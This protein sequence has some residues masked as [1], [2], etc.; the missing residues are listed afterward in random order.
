MSKQLKVL[1]SLLALVFCIAYAPS[2]ASAQ[3][4]KSE[5]CYRFECEKVPTACPEKELED[6]GVEGPGVYTSKMQKECIKEMAKD[7]TIRVACKTEYSDQ[8]HALDAAQVTKNNKH[9]VMAYAALWGIVTL[10][11]IGMWLRQRKL[12]VKISN[13]ESDLKK[14]AAE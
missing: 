4:G 3:A 13:L 6:D 5:S 12:I 10:F 7:A 11:V 9:V 14:A 1:A 8:Y 2:K